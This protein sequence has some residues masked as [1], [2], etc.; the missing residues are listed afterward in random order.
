MPYA[1]HYQGS[2]SA[3]SP[4]LSL[5]L[6]SVV[7]GLMASQISEYLLHLFPGQPSSMTAAF[8]MHHLLWL[9]GPRLT[10]VQLSASSSCV[11]CPKGLHIRS[12]EEKSP[13]GWP[14]NP[15]FLYLEKL[16]CSPMSLTQPCCMCSSSPACHGA[17]LDGRKVSLAGSLGSH[18]TKCLVPGMFSFLHL[19]TQ[20][21][22]ETCSSAFSSAIPQNYLDP[23]GTSLQGRCCDVFLMVNT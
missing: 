12:H 4:Y 14:V 1:S 22:A 3:C 23:L 6:F 8:N 20:R 7:R 21:Q 10:V 17:S 18:Y 5:M 2:Y 19:L 13:Q 9:P 16:Q 11:A 15:K